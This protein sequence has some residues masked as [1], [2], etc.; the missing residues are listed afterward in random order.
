MAV[1]RRSSKWDFGRIALVMSRIAVYLL[2]VPP[3][4]EWVLAWRIQAPTDYGHG[5]HPVH[6]FMILSLPLALLALL[7]G[8]CSVV[9]GSK[10][11][12]SDGTKA[13]I[14]AGGVLLALWA[15]VVASQPL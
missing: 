3:V 11:I 15:I 12:R 13:A 2:A 1:Q 14:V 5:V 8:L 7:A 10:G 6:D 4:V 9:F